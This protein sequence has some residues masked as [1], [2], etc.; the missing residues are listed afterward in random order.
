MIS[1]DREGITRVELGLI[2]TVE[3]RQN[4]M[5]KSDNIVNECGVM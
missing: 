2:N 5:G 3:I 1:L 4:E